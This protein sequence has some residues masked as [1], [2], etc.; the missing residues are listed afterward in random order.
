VFLRN[1]TGKLALYATDL[2]C[3]PFARKP[4]VTDDVISIQRA[5]WQQQCSPDANSGKRKLTIRNLLII[6]TPISK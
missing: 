1:K 4:D 2:N 6:D 5:P 3:T